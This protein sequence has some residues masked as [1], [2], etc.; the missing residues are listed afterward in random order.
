M[1]GEY[2]HVF[3]RGVEDSRVFHGQADFLRALVSL[4]AFNS[5]EKAPTNLSRF[6]KDPH[7]LVK[8]LRKESRAEL[9]NI[10]AFTLLPTHFHLFVREAHEDGI[11]TLMHKFCKGYARYFNLK[12][13][14][15]GAL[16]RG[17]YQASH[18]KTK[19]HFSHILS[20]VHLNVLDLYQEDWR[21]G[22][23]KNWT[24]AKRKLAN[25]PWSSYGYYR[26]THR[27]LP[28]GIFQLMLTQPEWL[29]EQYPEPKC[30]ENALK[31]WAMRNIVTK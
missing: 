13:D 11:P 14:R 25:Y 8:Y 12:N 9:V 6:V 17:T 24:S 31:H 18:V 20:Y 3:N 2:Y 1:D 10:V 21:R 29:R 26:N 27:R 28:V 23:V 15:E 7:K 16:W 19:E 5:P 22:D 30:F 4:A